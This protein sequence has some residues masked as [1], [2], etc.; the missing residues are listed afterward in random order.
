MCSVTAGC[1]AHIY[2]VLVI[3][4]SC[5]CVFFLMLR[6]PP[7]STPKSSS[8]ASDVFN[9]Q[10]LQCGGSDAYSGITANPAL[11]FAADLLRLLQIR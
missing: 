8:A 5:C 9:R 2:I 7:R 3:L 11:G 4:L 6:R 10:A 1:C